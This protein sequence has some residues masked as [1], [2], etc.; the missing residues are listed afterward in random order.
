M[1]ASLRLELGRACGRVGPACAAIG[2]GRAHLIQGDQIASDVRSIT[3]ATGGSVTGASIYGDVYPAGT[4]VTVTAVPNSGKQF[5]EWKVNGISC[6]VATC[7]QVYTFAVTANTTLEPVF[8]N[9]PGGTV[10]VR[11]FGDPTSTGPP[12]SGGQTLGSNGSFMAA[13]SGLV[14]ANAVA[15]PPMRPMLGPSGVSIG[16]MR[17]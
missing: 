6:A 5:K 17:P 16:H 2:S 8:E 15:R 1:L 4:S 12:I 3:T 14:A 7:P 11:V 10:T 13:Y 9:V